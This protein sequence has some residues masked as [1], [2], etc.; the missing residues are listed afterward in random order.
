M[1]LRQWIWDL[2]KLHRFGEPCAHPKRFKRP[3]HV[4]GMYYCPD[5]DSYVYSREPHDLEDSQRAA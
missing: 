3:F 2:A 1:T 4:D 5:C